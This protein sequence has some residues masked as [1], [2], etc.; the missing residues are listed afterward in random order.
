MENLKELFGAEYYN[1]GFHGIVRSKYGDLYHYT[2]YIGEH[3]ID[4]DEGDSVVYISEDLKI[5]EW[6][7]GSLNLHVKHYAVVLRGYTPENKTSE[8]CL[9]TTLPYVNGCSTRQIFPPERLGDPTLQMLIIPP[10]SKEQAHHI[11][12]TPRIVYVL[13]GSGYSIVGMEYKY[14]R[15]RLLPG[16]VVVIDPMCPHHFE[17][18]SERLVVIP[19]HIFSSIGALENN[20]P[21]FNGTHMIN[22]GM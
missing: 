21:M 11:H 3:I 2:C 4:I 18:Q 22:Q 7:R 10:Y 8:L 15:E 14:I 1:K 20:H 12:S 9:K 16:Q 6:R 17:T 13:Q 19:L 5:L